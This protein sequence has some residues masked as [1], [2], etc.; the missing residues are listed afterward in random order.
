MLYN[1]NITSTYH[2]LLLLGLACHLPDL[3]DS[4]GAVVEGHQVPSPHVETIQILYRLLCVKNVLIHDEGSSLL[5]PLQPLSDLADGPESPE[6]I[7]ELLVGYF[8]G[9]VADKYDFV[10]LGGQFDG[11]S[12]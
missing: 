2:S 1:P 8:V 4:L 7:I 5:I 10:D 11:L 3:L 6:N 9:E 12:L